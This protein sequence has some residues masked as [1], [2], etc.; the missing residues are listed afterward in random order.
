[1]STGIKYT[2]RG[3][4][5]NLTMVVEV[6]LVVLLMGTMEMLEEMIP[7]PVIANPPY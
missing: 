6:A 1:M 5:D 4:L 7:A 3:N 2:N